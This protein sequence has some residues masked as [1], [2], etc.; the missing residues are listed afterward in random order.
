MLLGVGGGT[1][2][3]SASGV[4]ELGESGDRM[5]VRDIGQRGGGRQGGDVAGALP[6]LVDEE[7]AGGATV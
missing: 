6:K 2:R 3:V 1:L 4:E 7:T 5:V